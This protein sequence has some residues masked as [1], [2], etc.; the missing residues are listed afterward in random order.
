MKIA[1]I[2]GGSIGLLLAAFFSEE[3]QE[4]TVC[5]RTGQHANAIKRNGVICRSVSGTEKTYPVSAS[6]ID[7]YKEEP[8]YTVVCVKQHQLPAV[9]AI[10]RSSQ[11]F[12][13]STLLFIQN[14]MGHV[15][16]L[17]SLPQQ[18]ILAGIIE[19]GALK[20]SDHEVRHTGNGKIKLA[21]YLGGIDNAFWGRMITGNF[22]IESKDRLDSIMM[23]KLVVNSVVNPLTSLFR[24]QNG[25]IER[26]AH[27]RVMA[28]LLF[29]EACGVLGIGETDALWEH[30]RNVCRRTAENRSSMLRDIEE[31]RKT[32]IEAISGYLL[33]V[34]DHKGMHLPYTKFVYHGIKALEP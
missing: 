8:H 20:I 3:G 25:D 24:V 23:E 14:G 29:E 31:G 10:L 2:G 9:Y 27:L 19:H 4:V 5:T 17:D 11:R 13:D 6:L 34:A 16:S 22:S 1:I 21:S 28:K 15:D 33:M 26:N 32:E 18:N 7:E 30:V 12:L